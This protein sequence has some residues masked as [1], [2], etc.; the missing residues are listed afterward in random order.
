MFWVLTTISYVNQTVK[1]S[2]IK[3]SRTN[4]T[5]HSSN[6]K[7]QTAKQELSA[8][9]VIGEQF[10][11]WWG[12]YASSAIFWSEVSCP[13]WVQLPSFPSY[14]VLKIISF[15]SSFI[16]LAFSWSI[17]LI[18][19]WFSRWWNFMKQ[20][21]NIGL[22]MRHPKADRRSW[23]DDFGISL[24]KVF[25]LFK[26]DE[27]EL[28]VV[29]TIARSICLFFIIIIIKERKNWQTNFLVISSCLIYF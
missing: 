25:P 29:C 20:L 18:M 16:V 21:D 13:D 7:K 10:K 27:K 6:I 2:C 22:H 3:P 12:F 1:L 28:Q 23:T 15:H 11:L 5:C 26:I 24:L 8:L 4:P 17:W 9:H 14:Y 19:Y